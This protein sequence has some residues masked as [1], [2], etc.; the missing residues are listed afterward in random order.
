MGQGQSTEEVKFPASGLRKILVRLLGPA[1]FLVFLLVPITGMGV[2]ARIVSGVA[3]WMAVWWVT[4]AV[5]LAITSLLPLVLFPLAG[6]ENV[7]G[8]APN[9]ANPM[10]FLFLAHLEQFIFVSP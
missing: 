7:H 4:E 5:P 9:Y 8:V 10:I 2:E 1:I 3:L 6:V